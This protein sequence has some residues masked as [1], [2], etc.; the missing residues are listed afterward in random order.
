MVIVSGY[1]HNLYS[2]RLKGWRTRTFQAKTHTGV[3]NEMLWFNFEPPQALHDPR[4]LGANF[5]ARQTIKRRLERLQ[6]KVR[7]MD[8]VE[9]TAFR[10][11]L[12][13]AYP[14][15]KKGETL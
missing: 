5:R 7:D 12:N 8:P 13:E 1:A 9:R 4:Y 15:G 14:G 6:N 3:R 10:E 11:W 2:A